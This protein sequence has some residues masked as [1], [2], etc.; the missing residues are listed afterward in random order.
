MNFRE[1]VILGRTGLK[2][3]RLGIASGYG[4]PTAAIEEAFERGCN[5]FTWGT[6]IKGYMPE[7]RHPL[8]NIVDK[9][10]RDRFV[11]AMFSYAHCTFMTERMLGQ[12]SR[13]PGSTT[14]TSSSWATLPAAPPR[15]LDGAL[16]MKEKGFVRLIGMSTH[17]RKL[18]GELGA[19]GESSTFFTSATTPLTAA[20]RQTYFHF[21]A[22]KTGP[23]SS[24]SQRPA[25]PA[26]QSQE[27]AGGREAADGAGLLPL[28]ALPS[29]GRCLHL[30]RQ[31]GRA[32][33]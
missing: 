1:P 19:D 30:R 29:C 24:P 13:A 6:V 21:S 31:D 33:A 32:D 9:G 8:K 4:A 5:Y 22:V 20:R 26:P 7:M 18:L 17:N 14:P 23:A 15:L 3:G 27:D 2:V 25:G 10:Q 16:R 12:V 11:L 28:R